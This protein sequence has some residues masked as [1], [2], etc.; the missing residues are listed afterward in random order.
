M[1]SAP[2]TYQNREYQDKAVARIFEEFDEEGRRSTLLVMPTGTGKTVVSGKVAEKVVREYEFPVLFLAHREL[3]VRQAAAKFESMGMDVGIEMGQERARE[4]RDPE[5]V[6]ATVQSMTGD[7][8]G[9]WKFNHFGLIISDEAHHGHAD[10]HQAIYNHFAPARHLGI[11]ATPKALKCKL[12]DLFESVAYEYPMREAVKDGWLVPVIWEQCHVEIDL[13]GLKVSGDDLNVGELGA[14]ISSHAAYLADAI[15]QR[16]GCRKSVVFAPDV[17][18]AMAIS[19]ALST[20]TALQP[21]CI[22]RH[23]ISSRYV[24]GS[25]GRFGMPKSQQKE[26]LRSF[27]ECEFQ[28]IVCCEILIEG[29]DQPDVEAVVIARPTLQQY[30]Y[31]QMV[32]RGTRISPETGKRSCLVVDFDWKTDGEARDLITPLD[33]VAEDDEELNAMPEETVAAVVKEARK[34]V[35]GGASTG[36]AIAKAKASVKSRESIPIFMR[37]VKA[38][39][40][41]D[42]R[43]PLAIGKE[44][45]GLERK[46]SDTMKGDRYP[47]IT[48]KQEFLLHRIGITN[49]ENMTKWG[50]SRLIDTIEKRR[51]EGMATISQIKALRES[52]VHEEIARAMTAETARNHLNKL[53]IA[54]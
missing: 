6:C 52:G 49:T 13:R 15:A 37:G 31:R 23:R 29:W 54:S 32:G 27:R 4:F 24:C 34:F 3:L 41:V 5:V 51:K 47:S 45:L 46:P 12:S 9:S 21:L 26:I 28:V 20:D 8:L 1:I 17:G 44:I 19:A 14:R 36:E 43:D 18:S 30:R 7:R 10:G 11:T 42:I 33:Y 25:G 22:A 40:H 50:A 39:F 16:V 53:E 38:E 35:A 48:A 2:V